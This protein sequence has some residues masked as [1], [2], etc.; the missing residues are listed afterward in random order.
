[1]QKRSYRIRCL[2]ALIAVILLFQL[3]VHADES[4]SCEKGLLRCLGTTLLSIA[5]GP[6]SFAVYLQFCVT[7]YSWCLLYYK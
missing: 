6:V 2:A 4:D 3:P 7:G 5:S 1:M